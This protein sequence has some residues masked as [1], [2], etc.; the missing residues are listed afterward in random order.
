MVFF[1]LKFIV[2]NF[3]SFG[4]GRGPRSGRVRV[5]SCSDV[6]CGTK[7]P[8]PPSPK[9]EEKLEPPLQRLLQTGFDG[10][11]LAGMDDFKAE[12]VA[13]VENIHGAVAES[14]DFCG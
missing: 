9:G 3:L 6:L 2:L 13:D 10:F 12:I 5:L 7:Y 1:Q 8:H 11:Q 14:C 4:R